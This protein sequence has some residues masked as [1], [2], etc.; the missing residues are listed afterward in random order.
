LIGEG[1][2][3]RIE[4]VDFVDNVYAED[5]PFGFWVSDVD[6]LARRENGDVVVKNVVT[7]RFHTLI[8]SRVFKQA[9]DNVYV[10]D[11]NPSPDLSR[12]LLLSETEQVYR[13]V[14]DSRSPSL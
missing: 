2:K 7:D 5:V 6:L 14:G 3:K 13:S 10:D 4:L 11:F 8:P 12:V 9:L 1:D